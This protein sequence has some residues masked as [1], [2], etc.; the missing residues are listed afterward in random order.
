MSCVGLQDASTK[1]PTQISLDPELKRAAEM[2]A[3]GEKQSPVADRP[4]TP[5]TREDLAQTGPAR[6]RTQ[7]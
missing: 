7:R 1:T 4:L 2:A 3:A 5:A 6:A